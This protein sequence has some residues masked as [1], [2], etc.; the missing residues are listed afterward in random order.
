[1]AIN[2]EK[3]EKMESLIYKFFDTMDPTGTN[4]TKY[5]LLFQSMDDRK[6]D[7]YFK[8]LFASEIDYLTLDIIDYERDLKMEQVEAG[9]KVLG[10][11]LYEKIALPYANMDKDNPTITKYAVP[12]GYVHIKRVQQLRSKKNTTSI[13]TSERSAITGQVTGHDKN[14]RE[15]DTEVFA[16]VTL[17]ADATLKEFLGPKADDLVM[18]AEMANQIS[19]NGYVDLDK[20]TSKVEN[21]TTLNTLDTYLICMGLKSDLVTDGLVLKKTLND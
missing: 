17:G 3:R 11:P 16:L 1:M 10:I 12:V 13:E 2:K 15:N 9:A 18:K 8:S 20:L 7:S 6:F 5:R 19:T 14:S 21:K 4:T